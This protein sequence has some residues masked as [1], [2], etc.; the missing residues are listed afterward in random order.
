MYNVRKKILLVINQFKGGRGGR[1]FE[2][3]QGMKFA[4][5]ALFTVVQIYTRQDKRIEITYTFLFCIKA[6]KLFCET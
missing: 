2:S 1:K 3:T 5:R 6:T 4:S